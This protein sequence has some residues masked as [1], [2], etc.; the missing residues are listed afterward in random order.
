MNI[1]F[2]WKAS[3]HEKIILEQSWENTSNHEGLA[4]MAFV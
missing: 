3:G 2:K 1:H 4:L